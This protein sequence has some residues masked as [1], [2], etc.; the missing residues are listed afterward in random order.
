MSFPGLSR[1]LLFPTDKD[2]EVELPWTIKKAPLPDDVGGVDG[3]KT[4]DGEPV[5][6]DDIVIDNLP[7]G[8][9]PDDI[10][11]EWFDEDGK[12]VVD[13]DGNPTTPTDAGE[14]TAVPTVQ[15]T[16]NYEGGELDPIKYVIDPRR[17]RSRR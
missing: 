16:D 17:L 1:K 5:N 4:F 15:P 2:G 12:P 11:Y 6:E 14:Y 9:T 13:E 10:T 3:G 8:V 7:D